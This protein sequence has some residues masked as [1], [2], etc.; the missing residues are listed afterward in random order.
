MQLRWREL[1]ISKVGEAKRWDRWDYIALALAAFIAAWV[2]ALKLKT[3]YDLGYSDDLFVSVQA[4]RSWLEGKGLLQDN[5]SGNVL[6]VHTY[7]LLLPL[8][9]IAKP[10]SAPG[11][12]FVLAASVGVTYLWATRI[13][14]LLG[15]DGVFAVVLAAVVLASPI[16]VFFY[17][18]WH[19]GFHVEDLAPALCLL[20]FYFLLQQRLIPSIVTALVVI[21]VKEDAPIAAAMVAIVAG[22]ETWIASA[23][24]PARCRFNRPAAIVLLLSVFAIPLLLAVSFSQPPTMYAP[25]SV[26]RIYIVKPGTLSSQGAL[27]AFV[28]SNIADWLGS[29]VVRQW[30]WVMVVG[31]FATILLRPYY[32]IAGVPTT[33]VAWLQ[34]QN[35]LLLWSPRL[36]STA[37]LLWCVTLVGFASIA[38]GITLDKRW[39][40]GTVLAAAVAVIALSAFDQLAL[41]P[42]ARN[43]YLLRSASPY[44]PAQRRQADELFARY[45]RE[46]KPD[47]P[48]VVSTGLFRYAQDRNLFWLNRL[49][50]RPPPVWILGDSADQNP[51]LRISSDRIGVRSE[52]DP[53]DYTL[54]DRRGRFV[55]LRKTP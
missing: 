11:L 28:L 9:L 15:I 40:Q 51:S 23:G 20:L 1:F 14:R 31:S 45:R 22:V 25:H 21:S 24:K 27:F 4:A 38:R 32:L 43:A 19:H 30:L 39:G 52:I 54:I 10:L 6:A 8:G 46:G 5:W 34:N 12:L 49:H 16:S 44:S 7:F 42:I 3:F 50:D 29:D 53:G 33:L 13:L 18:E 26:D 41:V 35:D 48:V 37:A 2:F 36:Y 47:E 55:L 17:Q